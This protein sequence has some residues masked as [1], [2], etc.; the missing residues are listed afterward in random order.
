MELLRGSAIGPIP[1]H[2]DCAASFSASPFIAKLLL[3]VALSIDEI[4]HGVAGEWG[5]KGLT[6]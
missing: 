2:P 1:N 3:R 6:G 4:E 5:N